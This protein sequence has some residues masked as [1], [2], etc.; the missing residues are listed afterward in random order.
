MPNIKIC[1]NEVQT[2][3]QSRQVAKILNLR[4]LGYLSFLGV[5]FL[6]MNRFSKFLWHFLRLLECKRMTISY[7]YEGVK[8]QGDIQKGGFKRM[9]LGEKTYFS[10]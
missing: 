3:E 9:V 5:K 8:E 2:L 7:L 4:F 1:L 6:F 10:D